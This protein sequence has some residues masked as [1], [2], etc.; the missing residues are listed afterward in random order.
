MKLSAAASIDSSK[1]SA[2][3]GAAHEVQGGSQT[4]AT[5]TATVESLTWTATGGDP[6][7][8]TK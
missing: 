2:S 6:S 3:G 4:A 1:A 7:L 8:Y 5:N